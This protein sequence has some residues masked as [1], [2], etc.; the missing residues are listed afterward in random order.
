MTKIVDINERQ[1]RYV[2][3]Q[4]KK[5]GGVGVV[6]AD[7]FI[8]GMRD[9][10]YKSNSW[11]LAE[12]L[13]NSIQAGA[14]TVAVQLGFEAS[15]SSGA[16]PDY[17][18]VVD[19]G[20]G[21]IPEMLSYA[22]RWGGTDREGDRDGF[23]RYG[24][25]L[26]SAAVSICTKYTVYSKVKGGQWHGVVVDIEQ[27]AKVASDFKATDELL[28]PRQMTPPAWI[29]EDS[30]KL[31]LSKIESGT[32]VVLDR[33]DRLDLKTAKAIV[34]TLLE[35]F[36]V[37]YRHWLP[38]PRIVVQGTTVEP[39]DPLFLM[40]NGRYFAETDV[41]AERVETRDLEVTTS[42]GTKGIV[43]IRASYLPPNFQ[44]VDPDNPSSGKENLNKRFHVMKD[45]HGLLICRA[46]RQIDCVR[47]RFTTM[48]TYDRN[49]KIEIDFDPELD[50]FFGV[51][52]SKQQITIS[53]QMW[54]KLEQ[55]GMIVRLWK[56]IK[57]RFKAAL[58]ELAAKADSKPSG[59]RPSEEAMAATVKF[60]P[61]PMIPTPKKAESAKREIARVANKIAETSEKSR[62]D[63]LRELEEETMTRP[64][65]VELEAVAE[66][67]FYRPVRFGE[68]RRIIINTNHPFYPKVYLRSPAVASALEVLL[69]VLGEAELDTDDEYETFYQAARNAWSERLRHALNR[70]EP[71]AATAERREAEEAQLE[72]E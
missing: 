51:T 58:D 8:R 54:D 27:L 38:S 16:K 35:D 60:K 53:E 68:Q 39:T 44:R 63:A 4:Q 36:G 17:L 28:K 45:Y 69:L 29:T 47:P 25:G 13:D 11:A 23:G 70:L 37:I 1:K 46:G 9:I 10:G 43:R 71:E 6:F 31:D 59:P 61:R 7:A 48:V 42:R 65:K 20:A 30:T 40:E 49:V 3:Q 55:G 15:N 62:E 50:E 18:A 22:V 67:P 33:L 66:G 19:N 24:Y 41:R 32:V 26:P 14:S 5:G 21:M 64:F 52:T 2:D 57:A 34:P 72:D 56:D 12:I